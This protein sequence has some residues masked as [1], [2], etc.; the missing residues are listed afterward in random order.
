MKIN[1][2]GGNTL[3]CYACLKVMCPLIG[4]SAKYQLN[5]CDSIRVTN[6][7]KTKYAIDLEDYKVFTKNEL[8]LLAKNLV[9]T[10]K[11]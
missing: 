9:I 1:P 3:F 2:N 10:S 8:T 6:E 7:T 11:T 5:H 4:A